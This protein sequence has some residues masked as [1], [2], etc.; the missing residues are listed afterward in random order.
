MDLIEIGMWCLSFV[1]GAGIGAI[2]FM[3]LWW[4]ILLRFSCRSLMLWWWASFIFRI[5]VVAAIF[6]LIANEHFARYMFMLLGFML[7]RKIVLNL[8]TSA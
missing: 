7:S 6:Y 3:G 5:A 1:V 4:T 8:K 2:F